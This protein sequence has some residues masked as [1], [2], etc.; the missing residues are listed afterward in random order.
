MS[1]RESKRNYDISSK[2]KEILRG[3]VQSIEAS[4]LSDFRSFEDLLIPKNYELIMATAHMLGDLSSSYQALVLINYKEKEIIIANS[5]SRYAPIKHMLLDLFG[6]LRFALG[7]TPYNVQEVIKVNEMLLDSLGPLAE[8]YTFHYTGHSIGGVIAQCG[9]VHMKKSLKERD[10]A[11][12]I[13]QVTAITFENP[14]AKALIEKLDVDNDIST[15]GFITINNRPNVI[16][17]WGSQCSQVFTI[18]PDAQ[19]PIP[20]T[21]IGRVFKKL[22]QFSSKNYVFSYFTNVFQLAEMGLSQLQKDHAL[23]R[24]KEVCIE[25]RGSYLDQSGVTASYAEMF[26]LPILADGFITEFD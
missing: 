23:E 20:S 9:A 13:S 4:Y 22:K 10:Q 1:K 14:G 3:S 15:N 26:E 18:V 5:G 25:E 12:A 11:K 6:A 8:N 19:P 2:C 21:Y 7:F 17:S 24:F 16:N